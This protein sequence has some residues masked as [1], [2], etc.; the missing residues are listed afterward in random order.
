MQKQ[1]GNKLMNQPVSLKNW[2]WGA[3]WVPRPGLYIRSLGVQF[4]C[5]PFISISKNLEDCN[6]YFKKRKA[7][8]GN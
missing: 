2:L 3:G 8:S 7:G 1:K 4:P 5:S 6:E